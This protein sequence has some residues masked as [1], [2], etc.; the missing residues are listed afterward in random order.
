MP[1][2][3]FNGKK[4]IIHPSCFIASN[5]T[6]IGDVILGEKSSVWPNAVIRGDVNR[7][8]IGARSNIQDN[9]V[10]HVNQE[11]PAIIGDE[12]TMGHSSIVHACTIGDHILIGMGAKILNNVKIGDWSIVAAGSVVTENADIPSRSLV[13]GLPASVKKTLSAQQ[14]ERI[15]HSADE[16]VDLSRKYIDQSLSACK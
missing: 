6:I 14:M 15:K 3:E 11:T 1:I 9:C 12:V 4:P 13:V 7:I 2:L 8:S 5:S 16:Y 10:V